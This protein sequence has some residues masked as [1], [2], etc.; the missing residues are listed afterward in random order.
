MSARPNS[1]LCVGAAVRRDDR[2]LL[3][4]QAAGHALAGQWS[5]APGF[6]DPRRRRPA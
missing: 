5:I 4:R 6:V 1:V 2:V 3:V